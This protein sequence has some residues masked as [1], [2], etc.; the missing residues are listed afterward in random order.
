MTN[1]DITFIVEKMQQS[2]FYPHPTLQSIE[3]IQTHISYVFLTGEYAYKIKKAVDFGF[4]D[5]SSLDKRKKYLEA[6]ISLNKEIA[7]EL[8][9]EVVPITK[10]EDNLVLDGEGKIVEYAAKMRQFPQ[11]NLFSNLLDSGKLTLEHMEELGKTVARFHNQAQT[12][13]RISNFGTI[14]N[15]KAAVDENYQQ[16]IPYI[17][18][19]Q[20]QQQYKETKAFSDNFFVQQQALFKSRRDNNK[21][22]ECHGDLHLK[23]ICLWQNKI[24]LFDRIEFNE[25]FRFVDVIYDIAFVVMDLEAKGKPN[26]ANVFLNTYLEQTGDWEGL[27]ILPLY[28]ARQAY[29]RAKVTSFLLDDPHISETAKQEASKTAADYYHQ[30]WEYTRSHQGKL[31]LMSG[32]SGSGKTTVAKA[33]ARQTNAIHIRSDAVRKHLAGIPLD[34]TGGNE[35]YTTAMSQKTYDRLLEL[36]IATAKV[37]FTVILDAKYDRLALRQP[38]ITS[39]K[40]NHIPLQIINCTAPINI[41]RDRLNKRSGD[42]SDATADLLSS[43]QATAEPFTEEEQPY[44]ITVD[45]SQDNWREGI[46][47]NGWKK[48]STEHEL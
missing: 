9:L 36:G 23:N 15:I 25:Q 27:L 48:G 34:E 24:Q 31:I 20:T 10:V 4:L 40:S 8:Y 26:F 32:L 18:T 33:I 19:V 30:A 39:A 35:I 41:L 46:F 47:F 16:T 5:F 1:I 7:P 6:E 43:Q 42:I 2:E 29:V 14:N 17:G 28:L 44:V 13:D 22:K 38:V 3:L 11:E 37:G 21:I 12:S 45:T